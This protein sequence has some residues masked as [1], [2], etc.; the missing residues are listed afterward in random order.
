MKTNELLKILK[1]A[2]CY[3]LRKG[4]GSHQIWYSPITEETCVVPIHP[5]KEIGTGL[6]IKIRKT[7]LG[8]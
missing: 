8:E 4:K 5:S 1:K 3:P 2:G 7:L 6:A